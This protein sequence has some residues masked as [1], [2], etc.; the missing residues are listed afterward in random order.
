MEL[1]SLLAEGELFE[2]VREG[3]PRNPLGGYLH[4]EGTCWLAVWVPGTAEGRQ[5]SQGLGVVCKQMDLHLV[6]KCHCLCTE[7][8]TSLSY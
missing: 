7:G 3:G 1:V 2:R 5:G 4:Q 8:P 6:S